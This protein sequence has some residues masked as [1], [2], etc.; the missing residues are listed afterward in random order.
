MPAR[1]WDAED[2]QGEPN[3]AAFALRLTEAAASY[4]GAPF[5]AHLKAL[6]QHRANLPRIIKETRDRFVFDSLRGIKDP[7]GQVRGVAQRSGLVAAGGELETTEGLTG[8]PEAATYD[9]ALHCFDDWL[10]ARGGPI[11]AE[12]RDLLAQV[13]YWFEKHANRLRWKDRALDDH[14]PEVPQQADF[15]DNLATEA[16]GFI[17][18]VFP[19]TFARE[20]CEGQDQR[21]AARVLM[22]RGWLR[23]D[24]AGKAT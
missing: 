7:S 18:Y 11:L 23:P 24:Q 8:W 13:R 12:E 16:G 15:K 21:D 20:L 9:A 1:I 6:V 10:K 5:V 19:E 14:A 2:L 4:C 22:R 17:Y 3:G